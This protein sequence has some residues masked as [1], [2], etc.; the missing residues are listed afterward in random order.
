MTENWFSKEEY[1]TLR[2]EVE[3]CMAEL[4]TLEK[5]CVGGVAAI[6]A[7]VA[8]ESDGVNS[9]IA[10]AWLTPSIIALYGLLKAKV[11]GTR[12]KVLGGYLRE[13]EVAQI[14][15]DTTPKGWQEYFERKSPGERTQVAREAWLGFLVLT[16][17]ASAIGFIHA[18]PG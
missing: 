1:A 10:L 9:I 8:K 14:P 5:A 7:W 15:P 3:S 12:L 6:F 11:I 17:I 13:I 18:M 16:V 4:G 2:K